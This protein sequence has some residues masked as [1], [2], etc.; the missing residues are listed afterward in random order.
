[1]LFPGHAFDDAAGHG[2]PNQYLGSLQAGLQ[3]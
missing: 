1:M 3:F 2:L